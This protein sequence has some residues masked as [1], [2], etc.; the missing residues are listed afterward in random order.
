MKKYK[1]LKIKVKLIIGFVLVAIIAGI[2]GL[3]GISFTKSID[4]ADTELYE[5]I[6][7][8]LTILPKLEMNF[9]KSE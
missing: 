9:S 5:E 2:V 7:R 3:A 1:D 8:E 6:P 4:N